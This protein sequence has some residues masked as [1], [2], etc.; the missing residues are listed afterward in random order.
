MYRRGQSSRFW[1]E[2]KMGFFL[3]RLVTWLSLN[4][5]RCVRSDSA[6]Y[7]PRVFLL[8]HSSYIHTII[9]PY[10]ANRIK[11]DKHSWEDRGG[12]RIAEDRR[13]EERLSWI[14]L[15]SWRIIIGLSKD[16]VGEWS[17]SPQ[18]WISYPR[19]RFKSRS[20]KVRRQCVLLST[21]GWEIQRSFWNPFWTS[22]VVRMWSSMVLSCW[23]RR[24]QPYDRNASCEQLQSSKAQ[25]KQHPE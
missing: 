3:R 5:L 17:A 14:A 7:T 8:K 22:R 25:S 21:A 9:N 11:S 24:F 6:S 4:I 15:L 13:I 12:Q 23:D 10:S 2:V 16:V 1:R 19:C 18:F 20:M